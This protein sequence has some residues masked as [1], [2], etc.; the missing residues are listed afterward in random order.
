MTREQ[1]RENIILLL[2]TL[3]YNSG[4]DYKPL[5][6]LIWPQPDDYVEYLLDLIDTYVKENK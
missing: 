2:N 1:L 5:E 4:L 3:E 6:E